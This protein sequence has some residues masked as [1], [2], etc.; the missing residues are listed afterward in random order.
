MKHYRQKHSRIFARLGM[1]I[2][3]CF[4][5]SALLMPILHA[6]MTSFSDI[7]DVGIA[8][9]QSIDHQHD[10][11]HSHDDGPDGGMTNQFSDHN[12]M[13]HSHDVPAVF[14]MSA[15]QIL[16]PDRATVL[17][18]TGPIVIGTIYKIDRPPRL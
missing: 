3:V 13:D 1:T 15:Q 12:P 7:N 14:A 5:A 8:A 2:L 18:Y 6:Q 11:G 16:T 10:Y 17:G 4:V 9:T